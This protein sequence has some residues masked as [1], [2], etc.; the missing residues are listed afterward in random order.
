M[1]HLHT[2]RRELVQLVL[3]EDLVALVGAFGDGCFKA[4]LHFGASG[5]AS[6]LGD[7]AGEAVDG[8]LEGRVLALGRGPEHGGELLHALGSG[9]GYL[10]H[11]L[12]QHVQVLCRQLCQTVGNDG[13]CDATPAVLCGGGEVHAKH[14]SQQY[15]ISKVFHRNVNYEL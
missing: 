14:H 6:L 15:Y 4:F 9:A 1:L 3:Q 2:A 7:I 5:F 11:D 13:G 10:A 8:I 12:F